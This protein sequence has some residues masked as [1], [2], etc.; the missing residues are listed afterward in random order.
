MAQNDLRINEQRLLDMIEQ[1]GAIG[2]T[3]NGVNRVALSDEDKLGRDQVVAWMKDLELD[4]QIDQI[5]NIFALRA[6]ADGSLNAP[7]MTGSHIDSVL[8]AGKLDGSYGVLAGLE[9]IAAFNEADIQTQR[10]IAVAVFTNEEGIRFQPDMMGSLVT[11]GGMTAEDALNSEGTDGSRL[12]DELKKIGY[13]GDLACGTLAPAAFVELHIEQGPILDVNDE[14]IGIVVDLQGI[15]WSEV[16]I[17]GQANHAGTTPMSL[18]RDAGLAAATIIAGVRAMAKKMGGSQVAT[19]GSIA[20]RPNV[21]NV[22]PA[23]ATMTI[24]LRNS[25]DSLL[26]QAEAELDRM[27]Q[28]VADSEGV[29]VALKRLARFEPVQFDDAICDVIAQSAEALG[30]VARR[31]TSG[32]G[33]DAQ[34]MARICPTAMIFVP[35]IKGVSHNKAEATDDQD[36]IKGAQLLLE[37]LRRLAG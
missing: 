37:T 4:V 20:L 29:A 10:P 26:R 17:E 14:S 28:S 16:T 30:L 18:R 1:L 13:A 6:A 8:G 11:A 25:N 22:V 36:L 21:I 19:V 35:S 24:D 5:G 15:S 12:G 7:V 31:M 33:H 3:N 23:G 34:M 32:A 9:I 2:M 27:V